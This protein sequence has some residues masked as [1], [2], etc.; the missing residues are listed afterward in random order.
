MFSFDSNV[1]HNYICEKSISY[2]GKAL[3]NISLLSMKQSWR[4]I[5]VND[6]FSIGKISLS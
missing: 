4:S 2:T 5:I 1:E 3:K 6:Q